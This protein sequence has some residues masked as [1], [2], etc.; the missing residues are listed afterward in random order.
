MA[1]RTRRNLLILATLCVPVAL[2]GCAQTKVVLADPEPAYDVTKGYP[3]VVDRA[4][5]VEIQGEIGET[6][7]AGLYL[8]HGRHLR[9]LIEAASKSP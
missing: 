1:S 7:A 6:E 3:R 9:A 5:K 8:I 4:V 2:P